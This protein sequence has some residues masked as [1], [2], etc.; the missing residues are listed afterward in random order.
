LK[1]DI[2]KFVYHIVGQILSNIYDFISVA[3]TCEFGNGHSGSIK[4]GEFLDW[5]RTG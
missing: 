2:D 4:C 3:G 5:L 1:G